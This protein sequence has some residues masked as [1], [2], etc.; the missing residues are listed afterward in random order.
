[1]LRDMLR[2]YLSK[3]ELR[4]STDIVTEDFLLRLLHGGV[5]EFGLVIELIIAGIEEALI[6]ASETVEARH[7]ALAFRRRTGCHDGM[8][9]FIPQDPRKRL[10]VLGD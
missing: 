4:P 5:Y 7:F 2:A 1:M 10:P 3:A 6:D 8:N 9:P